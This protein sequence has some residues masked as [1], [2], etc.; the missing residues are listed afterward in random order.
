MPSPFRFKS[1]ETAV[2]NWTGEVRFRFQ[3]S[4]PKIKAGSSRSP[5]TLETNA[6]VAAPLQTPSFA[7]SAL[8]NWIYS[9]PRLIM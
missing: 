6:L 5:V 8:N 2:E 7:N 9:W 4:G 3:Y 1:L